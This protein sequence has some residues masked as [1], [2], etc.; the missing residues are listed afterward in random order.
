MTTRFKALALATALGTAVI[1]PSLALAHGGS[2]GPRPH[3]GGPRM[4]A[5]FVEMDADKDGKVT[6][7]ELAA[8]HAARFAKADTNNDGKLSLEEMDAARADKRHKR[9]QRMIAWHDTDGD[10]LLSAEEM[11]NRG[12]GKLMRLDRDGD[13]AVSLEEL[14]A[15]GPGKHRGKH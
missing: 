8:Y 1:V 6:A 10:G 4:E 7:A 3:H 15:G 2:D 9:I 12:P 14:R 13:G 11:P 5:R